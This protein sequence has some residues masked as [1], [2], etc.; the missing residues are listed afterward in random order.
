MLEPEFGTEF[1]A[2]PY[3]DEA[4]NLEGAAE[5]RVAL[6]PSALASLGVPVA[7]A[8]NTNEIPADMIVSVDGTPRRRSV[9]YQK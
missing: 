9:S 6:S 1:V 7:D 5:V 8:T 4:A 2:L 3:A